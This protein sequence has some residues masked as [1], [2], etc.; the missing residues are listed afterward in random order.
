MKWATSMRMKLTPRP[1]TLHRGD[2]LPEV[3]VGVLREMLPT[4][5]YLVNTGVGNRFVSPVY[6]RYIQ[7][8]L[9]R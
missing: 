3:Q 7:R 6:S 4:M 5:S 9:C 1:Q 2:G 8:F